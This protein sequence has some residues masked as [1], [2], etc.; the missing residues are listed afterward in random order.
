V[1]NNEDYLIPPAPG[2]GDDEAEDAV[3][4]AGESTMQQI[5]AALTPEGR[6]KV[7]QLAREY[8]LPDEDPLFKVVR[9]IQEHDLKAIERQEG[10]DERVRVVL[11]SMSDEHGEAVGAI[12]EA[13]EKILVVATKLDASAKSW[14]LRG[15]IV[16]GISGILAIAGISSVIA[17]ASFVRRGEAMVSHQKAMERRSALTMQVL[18]L[19]WQKMIVQSA[20]LSTK[21]EYAILKKK[22]ELTA[23]DSEYAAKLKLV[24]E[25]L[26]ADEA[27]LSDREKALAQDLNQEVA[28]E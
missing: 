24:W 13:S 17:G 7:E 16:L 25:K 5:K 6:E 4:F 1:S 26:T 11:S 18:D 3:S 10:E 21:E 9:A 12:R 15:W 8:G 23:E 22:Q 27:A 20:K 28:H 14:N 2:M 19:S